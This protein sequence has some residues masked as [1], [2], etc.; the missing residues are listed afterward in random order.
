MIFRF[1]VVNVSLATRSLTPLLGS[2]IRELPV[3]PVEYQF[4]DTIA[5][6]KINVK[7]SKLVKKNIIKIDFKN[8]NDA[9]EIK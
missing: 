7:L 3:P 2:K 9:P 6:Q 1:H 4:Q 8:C 5:Y